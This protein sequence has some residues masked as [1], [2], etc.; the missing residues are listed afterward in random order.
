MPHPRIATARLQRLVRQFPAVSILGPRQSGKSTLARMAFPKHAFFDL[1]DPI[2]LSRVMADPLLILEEHRQLVF[3]E[4]QRLP[5][6]FPLLRSHLDGHPS[7]RVILLGSA[8]PQLLTGVSESLTGRV[9]F[10]ELGS[11]SVFEAEPS[12]LWI[13]GGFPRVHWSRPRAHP[14]DW[15]PAY[16]R[17]TLEQDLPQ[18]GYTVSAQ[19]LHALVT[20]VAHAQGSTL[21]L[22]EL[23]S[24]LGVSY[25]TVA[26]LLELLEGVY[27]LRR[28]PPYFVNIRK[29]LVKSPKL[30]VR[31]TGLLHSLLGLPFRRDALLR[32]PKV[33]ASFETFCIE[34]LI[35][36]AQLADPRAEAFFFRTHTGIEIDLL[37]R[38]RGQLVP[39]EVKLGLGPPDTAGLEAGMRELG[40]EKGYVVYAG[41]G[42]TPLRRNLRLCGL[43]ELLEE[44]GLRPREPQAKG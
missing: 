28:L 7:S 12:A 5:A 32:H 8:A 24:A 1:E 35:E 37:L 26:H 10:L 21:N 38:L 22:S 6:L 23:G 3:D 19:R 13:K 44:L 4:V 18:L 20:M 34:Q 14:E 42:C 9:G 40:L 17:T 2:A 39:I 15:F 36:H 25:H 30:Y 33:G 41:K 29:R 27:L 16:L 11:I 31:D 43:Q